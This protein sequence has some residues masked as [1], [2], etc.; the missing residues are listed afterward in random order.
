MA[1]T[2]SKNENESFTA[3]DAAHTSAAHASATHTPP[4]A[5]AAPIVQDAPPKGWQEVA[6]D[7]LVYKPEVCQGR[8]I[9]GI[10]M[11]RLELPEGPNGEPWHAY[12]IRC[13]AATLG[14]DR[15]DRVLDVAPGSEILLPE[16][17]RLADLRKA[18]DNMD[19]AWEVWVKPKGQVNLGGGKKMWTYTVAVNPKSGK[20]TAD[21]KFFLGGTQQ[22][23]QLGA[24]N[25]AGQSGA[26]IG[27]D[28]VDVPFG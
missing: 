27:Q 28:A 8:P 1:T 23:P 2:K 21:M 7:R 4:A 24:G 6:S 17:F 26:G 9:Q 3:P 13:T 19:I 10:L 22:A 15:E 12:V 14:V 16:T 5:Q 11:A 20:R 18:A 25:G